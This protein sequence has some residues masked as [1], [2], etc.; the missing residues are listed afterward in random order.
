VRQLAEGDLDLDLPPVRTRDELGALTA[1]FHYMRDSLREHIRQLRLTTAA[2][3]RLESEL[4]VARR[5]QMSMLPPEHAGS[6]EAG[7]EV[8][9]HVEPARAVGGD[10]YVHFVRR[11]RA[12]FMLG[13]V[14]GKGMAAALFMART[15]TLFDALAP[16]TTEPAALLGRLNRRLCSENPHGMFVTC[17]FGVLDTA[18]GDLRFASAGHD[19]PVRLNGNAP[20]A[21]LQ[22][23][24]GPVLGLLETATY[25]SNHFKLA[26]GEYLVSFTDGVTEA[27][28]VADAFFGSERLLQLLGN[29]NPQD[30][31][32][33]TR[34]VFAAVRDFAHGAIQADDITVLSVRFIGHGTGRPGAVPGDC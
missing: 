3:E 5:I 10:L 17:V 31:T 6:P 33:L 24:G 21:P 32:A 1:A 30:A 12:Y 4:K 27:T 15:K 16:L 9:A 7:Y 29:A 19:V 2:K 25:P 18:T 13:D 34:S 26:P 11:G 28:D 14:S 8:A 23:E 22:A 20:P